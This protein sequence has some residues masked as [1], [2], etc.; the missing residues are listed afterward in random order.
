MALS[1]R[2][3]FWI[4]VVLFLAVNMFLKLI[5]FLLQHIGN[6]I[7]WLN[8]QCIKAGNWCTSKAEDDEKVDAFIDKLKTLNETAQRRRR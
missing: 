5:I 1:F 8:R 2:I 3:I 6:A 7:V 4:P